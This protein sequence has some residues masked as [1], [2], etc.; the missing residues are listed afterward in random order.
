M[1]AL[2]VVIPCYNEAKNLPGLFTQL[3][4][5]LARGVEVILVDN[6]SSDETEHLMAQAPTKIKVVR[7][8]ENQGYG[9]GILMGLRVAQSDFVAWTHAD[10]QT[11]PADIL[12]A[13]ELLERE[14][15]GR[16]VFVKGARRGRGYR[17]RFI[18]AS[19]GLLSSLLSGEWLREVNAMPNLFPRVFVER[20]KSPPNDYHFELYVLFHAKRHLRERRIVVDFPERQH[21]ASTWN[22]G[23]S[24][25]LEMSLGALRAAWALRGTEP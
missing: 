11:D 21:G 8:A 24:S 7:L 1:S 9:R 14:G 25:I 10:L 6:G 23:L 4:P 19:M 22:R 13:F 2:S 16:D 12:R 3:A 20:L 17:A 15:L 5:L 18:S